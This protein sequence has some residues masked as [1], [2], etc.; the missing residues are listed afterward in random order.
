MRN[1]HPGVRAFATPSSRTSLGVQGT[2]WTRKS[3]A[4]S[5]RTRLFSAGRR[6]SGPG[7]IMSGRRT[8]F[9]RCSHG[10]RSSRSGTRTRARGSSECRMLWRST[11]ASMGEIFIPGATDASRFISW[12]PRAGP[13]R[14]TGA[15]L[16]HLQHPQICF[17]TN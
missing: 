2:L 8:A 13:G 3:W 10:C 1:T 14:A 5:D 9:G 4:M 17:L 15:L 12:F 6:A 11:G 16:I 7:P